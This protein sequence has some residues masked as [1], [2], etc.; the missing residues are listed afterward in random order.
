MA[1]VKKKKVRKSATEVKRVA[2][3]RKYKKALT[4]AKATAIKK[5]GWNFINSWKYGNKKERYDITIRIGTFTLFEAYYC[6][7]DR[8]GSKRFR[9]MLFNFGV[10]I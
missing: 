4:A 3:K 2:K 6:P 9:L 5:K 7:A 10:E 8:R 1:E